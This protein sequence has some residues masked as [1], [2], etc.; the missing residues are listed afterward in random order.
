[1]RAAAAD[2][3]GVDHADTAPGFDQGQRTGQ[4]D[5]AGADDHHIIVLFHGHSLKGGGAVRAVA[6]QSQT[7]RA[8]NRCQTRIGTI[9]PYVKQRQ[10]HSTG[11]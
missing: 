10:T 4:A 3:P 8:A 7:P 9:R 11:P 1:M 6:E 5:H 2:V